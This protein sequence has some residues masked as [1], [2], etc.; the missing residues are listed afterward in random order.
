[1]F[2]LCARVAL[3]SISFNATRRLWPFAFQQ[4][5]VLLNVPTR[6]NFNKGRG[7]IPYLLYSGLH[8]MD[9]GNIRVWGCLVY[10][11]RS[12]F[13]MSAIGVYSKLAPHSTGGIYLGEIS[14]FHHTRGWVVYCPVQRKV[15]MTQTITCN[16][17]SLR[18]S[19]RGSLRVLFAS[20]LCE[21]FLRVS[22]RVSLRGLF[23]RKVV[24][25]SST[26][27]TTRGRL[28]FRFWGQCGQHN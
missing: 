26:C 14:R 8:F 16:E 10:V 20:S 9:L 25:S 4:A 21:F 18:G 27:I 2:S 11:H 12:M 13:K 23:A 28:M 17:G 24:E 3:A 22:L 5:V 1:V 6:A 15:I 7:G 19:V